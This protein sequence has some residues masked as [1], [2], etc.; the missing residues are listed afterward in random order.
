MLVATRDE[1]LSELTKPRGRLTIT[2][3]FTQGFGFQFVGNLARFLETN[4]SRVG[5][6]LL[7]LVFARGFSER[8]RG[9]GDAQN[10][11]TYLECPADLLAEAAQPFHVLVT[12][13]AGDCASDNGTANQSRPF[14][15][16]NIF[17]RGGVGRLFLRRHVR[18]L[19]TD[20][21]IDGSSSSGDFGNDPNAAG[22][23]DRRIGKRLKSKGE[24]RVTG[25]DGYG[26]A[27]HFM[28]R[29]FSPA[30][31][32]VVERWQIVVNQRICVNKFQ[33]AADKNCGRG[34][35]SEKFCGLVAK[36]RADAFAAG[37]NAVAHGAV[38]GGGRRGL[39]RQEV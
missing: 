9:F 2:I 30:E 29:S 8:S 21:A 12:S 19:S 22:G 16:V 11:V 34:I 27:E 24:Q 18:H 39:R 32:V 14:G 7:G 31:I 17:E 37:E 4:E 28:I 5:G 13:A 3:K 1:E 36:D 6:F 20:H 38:D 23:L 35:G 10:V 26:F 25:E 15:A 33:G